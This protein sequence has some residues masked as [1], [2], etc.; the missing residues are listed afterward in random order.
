[1]D[2]QAPGPWG[3]LDGLVLRTLFSWQVKATSFTFSSSSTE[4]GDEI[5]IDFGG[6]V[7]L[8]LGY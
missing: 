8:T 3:P 5:G 7:S 1:M 6:W 4:T 2:K